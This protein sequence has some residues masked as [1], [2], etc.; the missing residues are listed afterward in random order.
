MPRPDP[1]AVTGTA[2][3]SCWVAVWETRRSSSSARSV[4]VVVGQSVAHPDHRG[5][6]GAVRQRH[7]DEGVARGTGLRGD[8]GFDDVDARLAQPEEGD[9]VHGTGG[10]FDE[11]DQRGGGRRRV[12][13]RSGVAPS[14]QPPL[15]GTG[16]NPANGAARIGT[17]SPT[18]GGGRAR[19]GKEWNGTGH[20]QDL[21]PLDSGLPVLALVRPR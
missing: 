13:R 9:G 21:R 3:I 15:M 7:I 10:L 20:M 12:D 17:S 6:D 11:G 16:G 4:K 14:P 18:W 1:T 8:G 19:P 5:D 2:W